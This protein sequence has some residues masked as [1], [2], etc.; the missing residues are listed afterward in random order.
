MN[1]LYMGTFALTV[2]AGFLYFHDWYPWLKRDYSKRERAEIAFT[3]LIYSFCLSVVVATLHWGILSALGR[4]GQ[5]IWPAFLISGFGWLVY[6]NV[7]FRSLFE[8]ED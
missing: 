1:A 3:R 5:V 2:V 7:L 6:G 8:K 4:G